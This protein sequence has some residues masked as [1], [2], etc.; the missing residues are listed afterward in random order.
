MRTVTEYFKS[1]SWTIFGR[2]P[3][4]EA[5]TLSWV[6]PLQDR[7][8]QL[9]VWLRQEVQAVYNR[10]CLQ[11]RTSC[12]HWLLSHQ[13]SGQ[14]VCGIRWAPINRPP[15]SS[16]LQRCHE[17]GK[18]TRASLIQ[19]C[20]PPLP[21]LQVRF[22][23]IGS[24]TY[25]CPASRSPTATW[26]TVAPHYSPQTHTGPTPG[27]PTPKLWFAT[28]QV[29]SRAMAATMYRQYFAEL[30]SH[31]PD[32]TALYTDGSF[33]QGVLLHAEARHSPTAF[34]VSTASSPPSSTLST[35]LFLS[36]AANQEVTVLSVQTS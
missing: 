1:F 28:Y 34:I 11:Y 18:A 4:G 5:P 20:V 16:S 29:R 7:L 13:P 25:E 27:Y 14:S 10:L 8:W 23:N 9:R 35:G 3:D 26:H 22:S 33:L 2:R 12:C 36:S 15:E 30:L 32:H 31:Y 17:V 6:H 19:S 21:P 24:S